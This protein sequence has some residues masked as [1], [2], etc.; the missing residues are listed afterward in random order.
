MNEQNL[1]DIAELHFISGR[2]KNI[3]YGLIDEDE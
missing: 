2:D 1:I 3:D